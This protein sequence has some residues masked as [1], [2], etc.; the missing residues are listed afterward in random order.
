MA[1]VAPAVQGFSERALEFAALW[2][3]SG[4]GTRARFAPF[5]VFAVDITE[6]GS[7]QS[8]AIKAVVVRAALGASFDS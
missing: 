4:S 5:F 6:S 3:A 8:L 1:S 7:S 2:R